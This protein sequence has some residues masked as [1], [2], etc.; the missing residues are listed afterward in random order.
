MACWKGVSTPHLSLLLEMPQR[1]GPSIRGDLP[2]QELSTDLQPRRP[3]LV[4]PS[5]RGARLSLRERMTTRTY[6]NQCCFRV[7]S[8]TL[9]EERVEKFQ[10]RCQK[11]APVPR[12]G[13]PPLL[14]FVE[15]TFHV[16]VLVD[17]LT[18]SPT[19]ACSSHM[20]TPTPTPWRLHFVVVRC[21]SRASEQLGGTSVFEFFVQ[22]VQSVVFGVETRTE[23]RGC[24]KGKGDGL[25]RR[26]GLGDGHGQRD[27]DGSKGTVIPP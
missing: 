15:C 27:G 23:S 13:Q 2:E 6:V 19:H 25:A 9:P 20:P 1:R 22:P 3:G 5:R 26:Q 8:K 18:H 17:A 21:N 10:C 12:A 14:V 7:K 4:V 16:R 24:S 11:V